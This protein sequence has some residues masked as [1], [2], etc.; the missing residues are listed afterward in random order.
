MLAYSRER[1]EVIETLPD[2]PAEGGEGWVY[3][4][5]EAGTLAKIF[6]EPAAEHRRE[7]VEALIASPPHDPPQAP[8]GHRRFAWPQEMLCDVKTGEFI[9]YTMAQIPNGKP[10]DEFFDP[11]TSE[12]REK[13]FRVR[14]AIAV[15]ELIADIHR[16]H[17]MLVVGDINPSNILAD[18]RGRVALIDLDSVQMTTPDGQN[19]P[20][21]VG[22]PYY[23]PAE[24]IG[25]GKKLG[26]VRRTQKHD[27][28][29]LAAIIFQLLFDGCHPFAAVGN[30]CT[31]L[32]RIRAGDWPYT[33]GSP[34]RPP[35]SAPPFRALP[36]AMQTIF[37]RTFVEG[38]WDPT[39]R[40]TAEE[41]VEALTQNEKALGRPP[42]AAPVLAPQV[43]P[44]APAPHR[45]VAAFAAAVVAAA[46]LGFFGARWLHGAARAPEF[47]GSPMRDPGIAV[48]DVFR[49]PPRDPKA[50]TETPRY[51]R[52]LRDGSDGRLS[53]EIA[54]GTDTRRQP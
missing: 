46:A 8:D 22:S 3:K 14:L 54:E 52:H 33:N 11:G 41:W 12:Y 21:P 35:P 25:L 27:R 4:T 13:P 26:Q 30:D 45:G 47:A 16:H 1:K 23:T 42:K 49:D 28:F 18:A 40:P 50:R 29:G 48:T 15:A 10:L 2:E 36:G 9:G 20:C 43:A 51:L 44:L 39:A 24:L 53:F 7:K 38:H 31:P 6:K 37:T 17:L 19:Y 32:D 5:T 34:Y